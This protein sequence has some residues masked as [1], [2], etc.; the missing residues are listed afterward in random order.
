MPNG[1]FLTKLAKKS[2]KQK[3]E[4]LYQIFNIRN[5]LG[6]MIQLKLFEFW[7]KPT[8]KGISDL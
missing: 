8:K 4:H 3:N 7:T 6:T 1:F 5:S 2:L